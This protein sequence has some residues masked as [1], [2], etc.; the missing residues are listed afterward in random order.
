MNTDYRSL[1]VGNGLDI[2]LG[3]DDFLNKWIIV[4]LL[5]K[6]K[7]GKYDVLFLN[8]EDSTPLISGDEIVELFRNMVMYANKALN[9]EYDELVDDYKDRD[10]VDALKDFKKSHNQDIKSIEEIGMEDWLL[11][12]LLILLKER[13]I[14]DQY[15]LIK[16][17]FERMI[18]DAIYC[19]GYI[20]TLHSKM[21]KRAKKYFDNYDSLFTLN[22]DNTLEDAIRK[23][24]FHLHG[25]F[26]TKYHSENEETALGYYRIHSGHSVSFPNNFE[27]CNCSAILDF[28]GNRKY[29]Y[30]EKMT[31]AYFAFE[32]IKEQ[33]QTNEIESKHILE[34]LPEDQ[35]EFTKIG[36]EKNLRMGEN[37][38]FVDFEELTG[39]LEIIGLAPQN[40][41]HIF[42][43]INKSNLKNIIFYHYFGCKSEE[44]IEAEIKIMQLP[45]DKDYAIKSVETIWRNTGISK[46]SNETNSISRQQLDV[47]NAFNSKSPISMSDIL[48]QLNSIPKYT[49]RAIIEMMKYEIQK[50]RYHNTP[51]NE[52]ELSKHFYDFGRTLD[53]VSL[54]PQTLYY[55]YITSLQTNNKAKNHSKKR[56]KHK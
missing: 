14:L 29:K 46:P 56:R 38:H 53:I 33:I 37:Y 36:I 7:I 16:Q 27:H 44:E 15:E 25:D 30:A 31:S 50:S 49:R 9:N 32:N 45:V 43:S 28:S 26:R 3:G 34:K 8:E 55:L 52:N 11:I 4:R 54:S 2:Q 24:V 23:T 47:L 39:T 1:L 18:F 20:Q 35:V 19:D 5:A 40:D 42:S 12:F 17:A 22:Y 51:Q 21:N 13:D 48:W 10:L 41:S 6:A